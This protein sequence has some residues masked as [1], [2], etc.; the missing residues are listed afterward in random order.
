MREVDI[1]LED[2]FGG[3]RNKMTCLKE[4]SPA[5]IRRLKGSKQSSNAARRKHL[6]KMRKK[7]QRKSFAQ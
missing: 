6:A 4:A 1:W 3:A 5:G 7:K 2:T